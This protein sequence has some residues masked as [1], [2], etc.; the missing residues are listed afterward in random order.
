M[1]CALLWASI[2]VLL[3]VG[4]D[5]S[6]AERGQDASLTDIYEPRDLVEARY[7]A[8]KAEFGFLD[9]GG[10]YYGALF[11]AVGT[12]GDIYIYDGVKEN[13]KLYGTNGAFLDTI[14]GVPS[15]LGFSD[16]KDMTVTPERNIYILC[17]TN[18]PDDRYRVFVTARGM[19]RPRSVPVTVP[20][21][22]CRDEAGY[23]V[24]SAAEIASDRD[25][26]VY[27]MDKMVWKSLKIVDKGKALSD[28]A[29]LS[30]L[31]DGVVTTTGRVLS[32]VARKSDADSRG[33]LMLFDDT[34]RLLKD[35]SAL[36]GG[37]LGTDTLG[38]IYLGS[39][40][41]P[42]NGLFLRITKNSPD[43]NLLAV[44]DVPRSERLTYTYGKGNRIVGVDGSIY[45]MIGARESVR[46]RKWEHVR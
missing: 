3:C 6:G 1:K 7:G 35:L 5:C 8:G 12:D 13:I 34:G 11:F 17:E 26:S 10:E 36:H 45:E 41:G 28:S 46:V 32:Y 39:L 37:P 16:P 31:R 33:K 22:F 25:G 18:H 19:D 23:R 30:S 43:G 14:S 24:Y 15:H 27:L 29:Q 44:I 40:E 21:S 42:D 2:L 38:N 9:V 20:W 4:P